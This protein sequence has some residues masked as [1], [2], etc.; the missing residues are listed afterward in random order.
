[1]NI[2]IWALAG[3]SLGW[4]SFSYLGFSPGRGRVASLMI[5]GMS[6]IMGGKVI[7]PML[8]APAEVATDFRISALIIAMVVASVVLFLAN[9]AYKRWKL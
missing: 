2:L 8:T 3:A 6:G 4:L 9:M 1:M 7:A 5:G